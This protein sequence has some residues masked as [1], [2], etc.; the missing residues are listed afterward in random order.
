MG[1]EALCGACDGSWL[2]NVPVEPA[3]PQWGIQESNMG[4]HSLH[5]HACLLGE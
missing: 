3:F 1:H 4:R 5:V 2:A